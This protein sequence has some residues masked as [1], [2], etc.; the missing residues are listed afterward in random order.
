[1]RR[2]LASPS[3]HSTKVVDLNLFEE[4]SLVFVIFFTL[5][6]FT[7]GEG[8]QNQYVKKEEFHD[9]HHHSA[10]GH[11]QWPQIWIYRKNVDQLQGTKHE[12]EIIMS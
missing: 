7:T 3:Q 12:K 8:K 1:M 11:L 9:V 5:F 10:Q 6:F 2:K 4:F